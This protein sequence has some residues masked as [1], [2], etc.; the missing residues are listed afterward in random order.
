MRVWLHE[1]VMAISPKRAD[2]LGL[3][4]AAL[5]FWVSLVPS[6]LPRPWYLQVMVSSIVIVVGYGIGSLTTYCLRRVLRR[7][8][9]G[10][11][12]RAHAWHILGAASV[13]LIG[14]QLIASAL[15]QRD[16][17]LLIGVTLPR[18]SLVLSTVGVLLGSVVCSW[19]IIKG[20]VAAARLIVRLHR[21]LCAMRIIAAISYEFGRSL[22]AG[23]VLVIVL[24]FA[25]GMFVRFV[26]YVASSA[27]AA[28][29]SLWPN[30][31]EM[32]KSPL[33]S[34][35]HDSLVRWDDLGYYGRQFVAAGPTAEDIAKA[36]GRPA[37]EPI[38]VYVGFESTSDVHAQARLAVREL[39]RSGAFSR[40]AIQ[41]VIVTGSGWV[42]LRSTRPLEY[43]MNGDI[44][45]VAIQ[46]SLLPSWLSFLS[47]QNR[48]KDASYQLVSRVVDAV[49]AL[50]EE[51]RPKLYLFG[52]SLGSYGAESM[53]VA[54]PELARSIAGTLLVGPPGFNP[55]Y[56]QLTKTNPPMHLTYY[57]KTNGVPDVALATDASQLRNVPNRPK[58]VYL[59]NLTD[60]VSRW[61]TNLL[62]SKPAWFDALK[63]RNHLARQF[64][65]MPIV[66][67]FQVTV[68]M[69]LALK[70]PVGIGHHY[71]SSAVYGWSALTGIELTDAQ[72][73]AIQAIQTIL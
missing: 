39:Q 29:N 42:D 2:F 73:Q 16:M 24:L 56:T 14:S 51:K 4:C 55:L 57:P 61:N 62:W 64:L 15:W 23:I 50:P 9:P 32:P 58:I 25:N 21:R 19:L 3:A 27:Y 13:L 36:M 65:W 41:I 43:V 40:K 72:I 31:Y 11:R 7:R 30:G 48:V 38:R 34:G 28:K 54:H 12:V 59:Q 33:Q 71:G 68:D 52:E 44:A 69:I 26:Q 35:S 45:T 37:K 49:E 10:A 60:P 63:Q 47:D 67:F 22:V 53:L 66:T 17:Y 6:L 70:M 8:W 20:L 1:R 18:G 5:F 46:Y